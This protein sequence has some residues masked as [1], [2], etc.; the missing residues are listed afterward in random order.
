MGTVRLVLLVAWGSLVGSACAD[1]ARTD[2]IG[3]SVTDADAVA[4]ADASV[5]D[6]DADSSVADADAARP[7]DADEVDLADTADVDAGEIVTPLPPI[8]IN[9][10]DCR[11]EWVE[12][13]HVGPGDS[14]PVA[15]DALSLSDDATRANRFVLSG[16]LPAGGRRVFDLEGFGLACGDEGPVLFFGAWIVDAVAAGNAPDGFTYGRYPDASGTFQV[17]APTRDLP[18]R[19]PDVDPFD[20]AAAL[21]GYLRPVATIDLTLL[22][23]TRDSLEADPYAWVPATFAWREPGQTTPSV[24]TQPVA[25]R[26]KGRIGSYRDLAGKTSFKLDFARFQP[27]AEFHGVEKMTLNNMVQDYNHVNEVLAYDLFARMRVPVPRASYV[28]LRVDGE[29][30]GLY[31]NL[32]S[33]DSHWRERNLDSTLGLFE[34]EYGDDLFPG[35]AYQFD[36]DGGDEAA[37][38]P[39]AALT[40]RIASAPEAGFM[41]ALD[42]F[43]DW[44]E[45]LRMMATEV[46]IG[47]WDGYASTR[48]NYFLHVGAD[49]IVRLLPWGLD[50]TFGSELGF[51]DGEGLLLRGCVADPACRVRW[52]GTLLSVA[53]IVRSDGYLGWADAL[54]DH[55]QPLMDAEPREDAGD[56]REGLEGAW[57]FLAA[58]ADRLDEVLACSRDPA[59]DGD[60]DG[61]TCDDD[62]D[63]GDPERYAGATDT[64]GDGIDQDCS[65]RA[66]DAADCP[67]CSDEVLAGTTYRFCWNDRTYTDATTLCNEAGGHLVVFDTSD[68]VAAV[69]DAI[70]ARGMGTAWIGLSDSEEE[71]R[72]RWV[73]GGE[74]VDGVGGWMDGQPDDYFAA[75]DCVQTLPWAGER[76]WNDMFCDSAIPVVCELEQ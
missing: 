76:P 13:V 75:E 4:D 59:A 39:L 62:C 52:E 44:D 38:V 61:H 21:Y 43:V 28:W 32:E 63:E 55:L 18:N 73:T 19:L 50:Q 56:A 27:D 9:E 65:G 23:G 57:S 74:V 67:D 64:C 11:A 16:V 10:F 25:I 46:F 69:N 72:F 6:R 51:Y 5:A 48:N 26:V 22:P 37:R 7:P 3:L 41:Q 17:T 12:L 30:F 20:P 1:A 24:P 49:G 58:R 29:D 15:L 31:L 66:D 33:L 45:L 2:D 42:P 47:H 54:A 14:A 53:A 34:G 71:S 35:S 68:E 8:V 36:L 70:D 60:G 40:E